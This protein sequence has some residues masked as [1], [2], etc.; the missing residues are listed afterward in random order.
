MGGAG[1]ADLQVGDFGKAGFEVGLVTARV[2]LL[3]RGIC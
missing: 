2:R 3:K 1:E